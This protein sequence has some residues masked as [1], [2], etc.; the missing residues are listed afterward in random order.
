MT[1][2]CYWCETEPATRGICCDF[3]SGCLGHDHYL[4]CVPS[5]DEMKCP[6]NFSEV[7]NGRVYTHSV[8]EVYSEIRDLKEFRHI[9]D[10][11]LAQAVV[12]HGSSKWKGRGHPEFYS[13][14]STVFRLYV[15]IGAICCICRKPPTSINAWCVPNELRWSLDYVVENTKEPVCD[16]C[17]NLPLEEIKLNRVRRIFSDLSASMSRLS[18]V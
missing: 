7:Y 12:K 1:D 10:L 8:V 15:E 14:G 11:D 17:S 5:P 9:S 4:R 3:C 18:R 6:L 2:V 16:E 13:L